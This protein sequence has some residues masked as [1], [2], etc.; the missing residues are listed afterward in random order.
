[1]TDQEKTNNEL[2]ILE[3]GK[4]M[5][6]IAIQKQNL[7]YLCRILEDFFQKNEEN[8]EDESHK[9]I[10]YAIEMLDTCSINEYFG[11]N[12]IKIKQYLKTFEKYEN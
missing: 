3:F 11:S 7:K 10:R 12:F 8:T 9:V 5:Y 6:L 2:D 1:M 4:W